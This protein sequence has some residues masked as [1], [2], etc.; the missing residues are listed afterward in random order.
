M[1]IHSKAFWGP[2]KVTFSV[3]YA[4]LTPSW[5]QKSLW[6]PHM[7]WYSQFYVFPRQPTK[8]KTLSVNF[9]HFFSFSPIVSF[10]GSIFGRFWPPLE[11]QSLPKVPI[12]TLTPSFIIWAEDQPKSGPW[13]LILFRFFDFSLF[14][15]FL[16]ILGLW[17]GLCGPFV[18]RGGPPG[19][20][21]GGQ[22]Q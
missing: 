6:G 8:K 18:T 16:V 10:F 9:V 12:W 7:D 13:L 15:S 4:D 1:I 19:P 2:W 3:C 21:W 5:G 22:P 20:L 14:W 11:V 17:G